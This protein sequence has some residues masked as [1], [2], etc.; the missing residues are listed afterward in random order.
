MYM[1]Q[2]L[3]RR[4]KH[5]AWCYR[6]KAK[7]VWVLSFVLAPYTHILSQATHKTDAHRFIESVMPGLLKQSHSQQAA[8]VQEPSGILPCL[9]NGP[10]VIAESS[11]VSGLVVLAEPPC[12]SSPDC[13]G[14][15]AAS[16]VDG[17]LI[18]SAPGLTCHHLLALSS[19]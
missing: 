6:S 4:N 2:D 17:V 19:K 13:I 3:V 18:T 9:V 10:V 7:L 5:T 15:G 1:P 14:I 8:E 11:Y 12:Q 16:N